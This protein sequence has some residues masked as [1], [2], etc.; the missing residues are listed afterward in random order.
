MESGRR[1]GDQREGK[2]DKNMENAMVEFNGAGMGQAGYL[3][4]RWEGCL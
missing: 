4:L 1:N 2:K 3:S